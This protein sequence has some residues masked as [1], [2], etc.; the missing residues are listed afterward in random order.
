MV[1]PASAGVRPLRI[2]A[3]LALPVAR[4]HALA[5]FTGLM[6]AAA[7]AAHTGSARRHDQATGAV[8]GWPLMTTAPAAIE[9]PP[10]FDMATR[11]KRF[12]PM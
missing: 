5:A 12:L 2:G 6:N 10:A 8:R 4:D 1:V 7:M 11:I 9:V 3:R